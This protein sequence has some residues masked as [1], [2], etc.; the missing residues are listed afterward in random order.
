MMKI[1]FER[2]GGLAGINDRVELDSSTMPPEE[3][4]RAQDLIASSNF[5]DLPSKSLPPKRGSADYIH[6]KIMLQN[7]ERE[8]KIDTNDITMPPE[9]E[10]FI[11]FL[12]EKIQS[13]KQTL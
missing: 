1:V 13:T 11:N 9:L 2:S 10:P 3:V 7:D 4:K 12:E 6:Y 8:H 5:F